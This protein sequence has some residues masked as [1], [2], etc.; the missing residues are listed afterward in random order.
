MQVAGEV[1][2]SFSSK[3]SVWR[4]RPQNRVWL[5]SIVT[6]QTPPPS[7][8]PKGAPETFWNTKSILL[9]IRCKVFEGG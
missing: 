9:V 1:W 6:M 4:M 7:S 2:A 8:F 5:E 3:A